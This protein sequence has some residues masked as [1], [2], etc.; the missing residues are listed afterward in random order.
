M[1]E[2]D[3]L[4]DYDSFIKILPKKDD[5]FLD[6]N[7]PYLEL[8]QELDDAYFQGDEVRM[9]YSGQGIRSL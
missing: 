9:V 6:L 4:R 5:T 3:Y 7:S 1:N 2:N 8:K